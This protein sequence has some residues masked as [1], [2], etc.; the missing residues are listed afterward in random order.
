M[1]EPQSPFFRL[2]LR[3]FGGFGV[4]LSVLVL[5][6]FFADV[7]WYFDLA[8]S[9][10]FTA[11][12]LLLPLL[13][14][15]CLSPRRG[16]LMV[17]ML[18][19]IGLGI[20]SMAEYYAPGTE[21]ADPNLLDSYKHPNLTIAWGNVPDRDGKG[22]AALVQSGADVVLAAE[23]GEAW[24]GIDRSV[25]AGFGFIRTDPR[26]EKGILVLSRVPVGSVREVELAGGAAAIELV[27]PWGGGAARVL[28][29]HLQSPKSAAFVMRR[30]ENLLRVSSW[31][32]DAMLRGPCVVIGDLNVT[33]FSPA[34]GRMVESGSLVDS[35][36]GRGLVG[37][38]PTVGGSPLGFAVGGLGFP[39]VSV[40]ID[41]C[42]HSRDVR[43][44]R[45]DVIEL[46]DS[47]HGGLV[48]ELGW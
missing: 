43:V 9:W 21:G 41:H 7:W 46:P 20:G 42:L 45:R 22:L 26:A 3:I 2:L 48:V 11:I 15:E 33:P 32:R 5:A 6:G 16:W 36:Q 31:A 25:L 29:V 12:V 30:N 4:A 38:W 34:Y 19:A 27:I 1:S 40:P 47:D 17:S 10:R 18:A 13:A 28:A 24:H 37:T 14:F 8:A 39:L 23:V 35:M 44:K